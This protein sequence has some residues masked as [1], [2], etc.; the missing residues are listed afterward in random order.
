MEEPE[1]KLEEV[2]VPILVVVVVVLMVLE[3]SICNDWVEEE[4]VSADV[5]A[6]PIFRTHILEA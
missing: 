5:D 6:D 2:A 3:L 4:E 1:P